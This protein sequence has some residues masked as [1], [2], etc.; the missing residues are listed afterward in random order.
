[1][2]NPMGDT[3]GMPHLVAAPDKWRGSASAAEIASAI[4][5]AAVRC[6]W[7]ADA[8]PVSDGGEGFAAVL[9]GRPHLERVRGPLGEPVRAPWYLLD[10]GNTATVE[11]ALASGLV[12]AGGA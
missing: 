7:T 6:G 8:A 5:D 12:L 10:D 2:A 11:M 3:G 1:M 4:V 9:G